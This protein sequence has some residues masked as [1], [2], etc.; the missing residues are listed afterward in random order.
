[1]SDKDSIKR[2]RERI[3]STLGP[4]PTDVEEPSPSPTTQLD[5]VQQFQQLMRDASELAR[6]EVEERERE[7][8]S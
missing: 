4:T 1:M 6:Q 3:R 5:R 7:Q 8:A 2:L